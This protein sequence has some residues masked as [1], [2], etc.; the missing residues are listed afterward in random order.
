VDGRLLFYSLVVVGVWWV[1][2]HSLIG[3][4]ILGALVL[5]AAVVWV[6]VAAGERRDRRRHR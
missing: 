3:G 4:V 2:T 6:L 5:A 1:A